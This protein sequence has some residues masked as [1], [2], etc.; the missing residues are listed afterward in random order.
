MTQRKGC[1]NIVATLVAGLEGKG[2]HIYMDNFYSLPELFSNL[3][4]GIWNSDNKQG[5]NPKIFSLLPKVCLLQL[6]PIVI[7]IIIR[8]SNCKNT[9]QKMTCLKWHDKRIV[10]M[11]STFHDGE[12]IEKTRRQMEVG[13]W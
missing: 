9:G 11:L 5:W 10:T 12:L 7:I 1:Q 8:I 3:F 13:K 6:L 4:Q 2:Y